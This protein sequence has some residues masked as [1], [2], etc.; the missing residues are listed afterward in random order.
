MIYLLTGANR[1]ALYLRL[2]DLEQSSQVTP[3]RID[4]DDVTPA[5]LGERLRTQSLF[6]AKRFVVVYD[7]ATQKDSWR[8]IGEVVDIIDEAMTLVLVDPTI[9]RRSKTYKL[10]QKFAQIEQFDMLSERQ[11]TQMADWTADYARAQGCVL[12]PDQTRLVCERSLVPD[13][14]PGQY[15]YDQ[16]VAMRAIDALAALDAVDQDAIDAVM[17]ASAHTN[18]FELF[19]AILTSPASARTMAGQLAGEEDAHMVI[20]LMAGQ[21]QQLIAIV[22]SDKSNATVANDIGAHPFALQQLEPL[23]RSID[24]VRL[25]ELVD[26]F[27]RADDRMKSS[28]AVPWQVIYGLIADVEAL[29]LDR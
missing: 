2:K 5:E 9:D 21:L 16:S 29:D 10:L 7:A 18:V 20:A 1:A 26:I 12:A 24:E 17:P 13:S 11:A 15:V 19:R 27:V 25:W 22:V 8:V 28:A 6:D 3:E 14:R 23:A 4:A